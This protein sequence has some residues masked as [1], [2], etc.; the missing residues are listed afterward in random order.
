VHAPK[1]ID[2]FVHHPVDGQIARISHIIS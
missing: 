1:G 2:A